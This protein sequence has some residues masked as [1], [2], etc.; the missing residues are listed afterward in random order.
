[1]SENEKPGIEKAKLK[2]T[3]PAKKERKAMSMRISRWAAEMKSEIKKI[4]WPG[5]GQVA[6]NTLVVLA[7]ILLI[8][9]IIWIFDFLLG[10]GNTALRSIVG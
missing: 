9:S 5:A 7:A 6:N 8:G 3:K 4:R 2:D 10:L 1:M